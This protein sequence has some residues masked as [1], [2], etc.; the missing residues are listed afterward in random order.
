[1]TDE[2]KTTVI[3]EAEENKVDSDSDS[4]DVIEDAADDADTADADTADAVKAKPTKKRTAKPFR[5]GIDW[6]RVFA[7][8]VL[9]GLALVLALAAGFLKY[10]DNSVRSSDVARAESMQVAKDSTIAL[11]SYQPD[12]VKDQLNAARSLL[13]GDFQNSYTSLINDVVIPGAEQKKISAVA[14]VPAAA[15]VSAQPNHAVVLVFVN[16]TVIVGADAPTDTASSVKVTL[17]KHGDKWLISEFQ[18]V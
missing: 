6:P 9:P 3:D 8:G 17:D 1:M 13:T 11:L 10:V 16:Q 15:S 7:Y 14:T 12:K 4:K 2:E 18:P 5:P